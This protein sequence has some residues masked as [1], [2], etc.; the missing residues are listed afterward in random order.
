V[1]AFKNVKWCHL[2]W[3]T[4]YI[5]SQIIKSK[6][7]YRSYIQSQHIYIHHHVGL[8]NKIIF[9]HCSFLHGLNS[10]F[11]VMFIDAFD[12]L[13]QQQTTVQQLHNYKNINTT[14]HKIADV[15]GISEVRLWP[16]SLFR[17]YNGKLEQLKIQLCF[18]S[19]FL[20]I[21]LPNRI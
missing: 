14:E 16:I 17:T 13:L 18:Y 19:R 11:K 7:Y 6:K 5:Q 21:L 1:D 9:R 3:P 2:I 4:L 15:I 12:Y 8:I 20:I 10:N